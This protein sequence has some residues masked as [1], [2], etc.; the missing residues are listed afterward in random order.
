MIGKVTI[1][2]S[3]GRVVRYAME[4]QEASLLLAE[5]VRKGQVHSMIDDF[6]MQRKLNPDLKRS[7]AYFTQLEQAGRSPA[8]T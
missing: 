4:K 6:N 3:F 2:S 1:G 5:G 7:R 8:N